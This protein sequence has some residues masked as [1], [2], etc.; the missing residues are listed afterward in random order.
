[1]GIIKKIVRSTFLALIILVLPQTAFAHVLVPDLTGKTGAILHLGTDD[2]PVAGQLSGI[3]YDVHTD[4]DLSKTTPVL[5]VTNAADSSQISVPVAASGQSV[6]GAY[7]FPTRGLY[8]LNLSINPSSISPPFDSLTFS[9]SLRVTAGTLGTQTS[10]PDVPAWAPAGLAITGWLL[11]ML[12]ITIFK[13]RGS[14]SRS[15]R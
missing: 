10:N 12:V 7:V 3:F 6:H 5:I 8:Y 13:R 4:L 14:I 11:L 9:Y 2:N 1:M 15:S